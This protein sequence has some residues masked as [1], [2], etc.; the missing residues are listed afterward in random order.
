MHKVLIVEV[1]IRLFAS[2][3][4]KEKR[5]VFQRLVDRLK[6]AHNISIAET[7]HRDLWNMIGITIAYVGINQTKALQKAHVLENHMD[8]IL[9]QDGSGEISF[10]HH[11]II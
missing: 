8:R 5:G 1:E 3:S 11:E 10:F 9:D 2:N 4:L 7:G 6:Q